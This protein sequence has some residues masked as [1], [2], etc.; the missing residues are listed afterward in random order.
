MF[1][2]NRQNFHVERHHAQHNTNTTPAFGDLKKG[3]AHRAMAISLSDTAPNN[4]LI[5]FSAKF[6][7]SKKNRDEKYNALEPPRKTGRALRRAT[8]NVR[9]R[10]APPARHEASGKQVAD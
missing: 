10:G 8:R 4:E 2:R 3:M 9:C 6:G 7:L 1:T 5:R